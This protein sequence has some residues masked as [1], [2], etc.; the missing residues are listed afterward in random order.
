MTQDEDLF[1]LIIKN[2]ETADSGRYTCVIRECNDLTCK[3]A[4][5]VERK[6]FIQIPTLTLSATGEGTF[7]CTSLLDQILSADFFQNFPNSFGGEN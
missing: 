5:D 4:L 2:P 1:T 3:A 7:T 6:N